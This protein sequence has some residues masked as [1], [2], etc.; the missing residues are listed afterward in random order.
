M[1]EECRPTSKSQRV[2]LL[3]LLI[4]STII[5]QRLLAFRTPIISV[6]FAFLPIAIAGIV[7]GGKAAILVAVTADLIGALVLPSG[8]FFLGYTLTAFFNG[9]VAGILHQPK[10]ITVNRNFIWRLVLFVVISTG[11]L[12][13]GL[14]TLWIMVTTGG[15]SNIIVP[16][17]IAK[18]LIM[19]PIEFFT[20]LAVVK[21][22]G[23]Q[24][25][26]LR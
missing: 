23:S 4:A 15:A 13:G 7:L 16:L 25:E 10:Q 2:A 17:R 18:Q 8:P 6:N 5:L 20:I 11:V 14:N 1:S 26:N 9:L 19:A 24:M 22:F 3:A 12:Q 21:T